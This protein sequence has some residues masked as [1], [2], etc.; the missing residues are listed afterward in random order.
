MVLLGEEVQEKIE[1]VEKEF[2]VT[3]ANKVGEAVELSIN[4]VVGLTSSQTMKVKGLIGRQEVVVLIDYGAT[5]NFTSTELVQRLELPRIETTRYGV[6]MG[7]RLAVQGAGIFTG[8]VLV[9]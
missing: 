5:Y 2:Y 4:L 1:E 8:V 3:E 6:I 9:L 7:T